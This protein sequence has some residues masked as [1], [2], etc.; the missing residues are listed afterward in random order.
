MTCYSSREWRVW[1]SK[2]HLKEERVLLVRYKK[3]TGKATFNQREAMNEAICFGWI[4]TTLKRL[5]D[6][7]YGVK[8]VRRNKNSRWSDNTFARAREMIKLGKMS[9]F[10]REMFELGLTKKTLGHGIPKN[11]TLFDVPDLK[12]E[13]DKNKNMRAKEA[14]LKLAPSY[15]RMYFRW[16]LSAKRVE[17]RKKR[18]RVCVENVLKGKKLYEGAAGK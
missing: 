2:N 6:D 10:G 5:D 17:T 11:P 4:D 18:M 3:H 9:E 12:A 13:L 15:K 7:R 14:F 1:L 8:F 16:I